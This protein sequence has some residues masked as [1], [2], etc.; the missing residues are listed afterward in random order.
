MLVLTI[1]GNLV[2][3]F[4]ELLIFSLALCLELLLLGLNLGLLLLGL[5]LGFLDLV[6]DLVLDLLDRAVDVGGGREG[7]GREGRVLVIGQVPLRPHHPL[8]KLLSGRPRLWI[9][10]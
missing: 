10:V 8:K 5:D 4:L 1:Y 2:M 3:S 6:L 9:G 7:R